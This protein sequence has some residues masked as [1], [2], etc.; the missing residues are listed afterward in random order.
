MLITIILLILV[1]FIFA[2][3]LNTQTIVK[4]LSAIKTK[5]GMQDEKKPSIFD[6]DLDN[7]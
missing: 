5:L 4:D 7:D 2:T 6:K 1:F 3:W